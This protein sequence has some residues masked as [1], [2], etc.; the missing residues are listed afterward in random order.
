VAA[1]R[2]SKT[3]SGLVL[4]PFAWLY[5]GTFGV[6]FTVTSLGLMA[7]RGTRSAESAAWLV[8]S[9]RVGG[10]NAEAA[11]DRAQASSAAG[12]WPADP[13]TLLDR[14]EVTAHPLYPLLGAVP[15]RLF[16]TRGLLL[17]SLLA[18][19][20][21]Y[22]L[23]AWVLLRCFD[24][25]L[26][27]GLMVLSLAC[28]GPLLCSVR[29]GP[30]SLAAA[31]TALMLVAAWRYQELHHHQRHWLGAVGLAAALATLTAPSV[32]IG[33][34]ALTGVY[35]WAAASQRSWSNGWRWPLMVAWASAGL[36]HLWQVASGNCDF[37]FGHLAALPSAA[38]E[39]FQESYLAAVEADWA[40]LALAVVVVVSLVACITS[41]QSALTLGGLAG[42]V[43]WAGQ[44]PVS[45]GNWTLPALGLWLMSSGRL[46][47]AL[48]TLRHASTWYWLTLAGAYG[49]LALT[50]ARTYPL[51]VPDSKH[52]YAQALRFGGMSRA[53]LTDA[54]AA[55]S[56]HWFSAEYLID[57]DLVRP[58]VVYPLIAT[59]AVKL[60]GTAG[61]IATAVV[62]SVAFY[63]VAAWWLARRFGRPLA[64]PVMILALGC[65]LWLYFSMAAITESLTC[66]WAAL[67][68]VV[69]WRYMKDPAIGW[70]ACL[71]GLVLISAFTRQAILVP[72]AGFGLALFGQRLA[73][74]TW[75]NRF[76]G[77]GLVVGGF[78]LLVQAAQLV[79]WPNV[80]QTGALAESGNG[81]GALVK[82]VAKMTWVVVMTEPARSLRYHLPLL[83][84]V[85]VCLMAL[86]RHW[87]AI[88]AQVALG[89]LF[90]GLVYT[91]VNGTLVTDARYFQPAFIFMLTTVGAYFAGRRS[92][93]IAWPRSGPGEALP[94]AKA[95]QV[96]HVLAGE[97]RLPGVSQAAAAR[98]GNLDLC[99]GD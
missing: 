72:A 6:L 97:R 4:K 22:W 55:A 66:L 56:G 64:L 13:Q 18:A 21:V 65:C 39:T 81:I 16:G 84:V 69:T 11:L 90:G 85:L 70:L 34:G 96:D 8:Q 5:W 77:P 51:F 94:G 28:A 76:T 62:A 33:L 78:G 60:W 40:V 98:K 93:A 89:G 24:R 63:S 79:I 45:P 53:D 9:L 73:R 2:A 31:L 20:V 47:E 54:V 15:V 37:W 26:A 83:V 23:I 35:L 71:A 42:V 58:R 17:V 30:G 68:V 43:L 61:L 88:E 82:S 80:S 87:R 3:L 48:R 10:L 7:A 74:G 25:P 75:R 19:L 95:A 44:A 12:F 36:V 67:M 32:L 86:L 14:P 50:V 1:G 38:F 57:W 59:P 91:V 49:L 52:Y 99:T 27:L 46:A 41:P 92:C 29:L